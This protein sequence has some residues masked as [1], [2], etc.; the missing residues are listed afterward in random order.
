MKIFRLKI[1]NMRGPPRYSG[2]SITPA[3]NTLRTSIRYIRTSISA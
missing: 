1:K 3:L 2:I